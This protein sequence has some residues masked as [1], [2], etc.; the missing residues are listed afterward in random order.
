MRN[1]NNVTLTAGLL[2]CALSITACS[3]GQQAA[4]PGAPEA[5]GPLRL[6]G[7]CPDTVVLQ[8]DWA[9]EAEHGGSY[10]LLG[11]KHTIDAGHKRVTGPLV[12]SG[13][14]TGVDIE[15]RAGGPAVGFQTVSSQMY[16]DPEITL[17]QVITDEAVS[18][19]ASQ[20]TLAVVAPLD[21]SPQVIMWDPASHPRVDTIADLGRTDTKVLYFKAATFMEYLVGS[22]IL[23]E[24]QIDGSYDGSPASFI[25]SDGKI[26]QQAFATNEPYVYQKEISQWR[27][28]VDFQLLHETGYPVY[29]QS[30]SIRADQKKKL[31][32]CL[33]KL[34]PIIQQAQVD[35]LKQPDATNELLVD[36]VEE[37]N[38]GFTYSR[39]QAEFSVKQQLKLNIAGNGPDRTLG[40]FEKSRL[41]RV[42]DIVSPVVAERKKDVRPDLATGE[43]AT[44]EF[45][46]PAIGYTR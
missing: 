29:P 7:V 41:Q 17:G 36:L 15:I 32:P 12:A 28:P 9:P 16:L 1:S 20:P 27:K 3:G 43:I 45:I 25:A 8:T 42:I 5:S 44:N 34:V 30:L 18:L 33:K 6:K 19:S 38:I 35:Y 40:N 10:H 26:A 39:K 21:I 11:K 13:T 46:D 22:K 24:D 14:D 4:A 31:T 2:A 37:Y 23:Q